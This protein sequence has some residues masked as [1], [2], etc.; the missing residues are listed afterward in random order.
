MR[1]EMLQC[2]KRL[3]NIDTSPDVSKCWECFVQQYSF[4]TLTVK[5]RKWKPPAAQILRYGR[6]EGEKAKIRSQIEEWLQDM[7]VGSFMSPLFY[8]EKD[9]VAY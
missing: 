2:N 7:Q 4:E 8:K 9:A 1:A 3:H 6:R 5:E